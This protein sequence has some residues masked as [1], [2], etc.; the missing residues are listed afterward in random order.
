MA[1]T[2]LKIKVLPEKPETN[3]EELKEG[4]E[5]SLIKAGAIKISFEIEEIAFGLKALIAIIAWPEE[6]ETGEAEDAIKK[7]ANVSSQEI[8][9]YRRAFG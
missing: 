6:K 7:V 4:I 8:I 2:A 3:L 9:D 1:I 5:E